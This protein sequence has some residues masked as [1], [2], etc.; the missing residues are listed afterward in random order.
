[1]RDRALIVPGRVTEHNKQCRCQIK[2]K[3]FNRNTFRNFIA[4]LQDTFVQ[5]Q[6]T[7]WRRFEIRTATNPS[8][9]IP[10]KATLFARR[11]AAKKSDF[12][13]FSSPQP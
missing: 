3:H 13:Q 2:W 5:H 4:P 12:F 11:L 6:D 1:M 10:Y 9:G 8:V 7:F